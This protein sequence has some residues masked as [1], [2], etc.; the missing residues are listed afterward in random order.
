MVA[1][2]GCVCSQSFKLAFWFSFVRG[3]VYSFSTIY[4][5]TSMW[6][7]TNKQWIDTLST[8]GPACIV[9]Q[10]TYLAFHC[11]I[12][13]VYT[14]LKTSC[15]R[16]WMPLNTS[17]VYVHILLAW[18]HWVGS[19]VQLKDVTGFSCDS[20]SEN[21]FVN[22]GNLMFPISFACVHPC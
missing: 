3:L 5:L 14:T 10:N 12:Y 13:I 11:D 7:L 19:L 21:G 4:F 22:W 15:L 9:M 17:L 1:L 18:E 6:F 2:Y 16:F 8:A 20:Q